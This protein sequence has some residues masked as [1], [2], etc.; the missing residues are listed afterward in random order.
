L[1]YCSYLA[2]NLE[3]F[4]GQGSEDLIA[5]GGPKARALTASEF[6]VRWWLRIDAV[7]KSQMAGSI[8]APSTKIHCYVLMHLLEQISWGLVK[9]GAN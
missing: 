4:V 9:R 1:K 7:L 6:A 5:Q 2:W 8:I 3:G